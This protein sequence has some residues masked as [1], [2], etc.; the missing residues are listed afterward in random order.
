M[1]NDLSVLN[2]PF[3]IQ[4]HKET[5]INYLEVIIDAN[6]NIYYAVPSHLQKLKH[7]YMARYNATEDQM[8]ADFYNQHSGISAVEYFCAKLDCISVWWDGYVGEPKDIH[9]ATLR[10]LSE[11]GIYAGPVHDTTEAK[12][13]ELEQWACECT[14]KAEVDDALNPKEIKPIEF[15]L[16][17]HPTPDDV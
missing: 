9:L 17:S 2:G 10:K 4:K 12:R 7:M 11:A 13:E 6:G 15:S 3:S 5:F 14:M 8:M 16:C 1:L